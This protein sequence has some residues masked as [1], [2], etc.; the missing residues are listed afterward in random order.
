MSD[1]YLT[2][3]RFPLQTIWS[4]NRCGIKG[5]ATLMSN[6]N[7]YLE[8]IIKLFTNLNKTT[9]S[10]WRLKLYMIQTQLAHAINNFESTKKNLLS[11]IETNQHSSPYKELF[12]RFNIKL[13]NFRTFIGI[14]KITNNKYIYLSSSLTENE[15]R[16]MLPNCSSANLESELEQIFGLTPIVV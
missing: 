8:Q 5:L 13:S 10:T 15:V 14:N 2:K 7:G 16:Q 4:V 12:V 11:W 3:L 9:S 1:Q 6:Y